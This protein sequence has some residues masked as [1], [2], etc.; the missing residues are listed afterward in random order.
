MKRIAVL[1]IAAILVL[2]CLPLAAQ[3]PTGGVQIPR[4]GTPTGAAAPGM[5]APRDKQGAAQSGTASLRGRVV[6]AQTGMPLRRAQVTIIAPESQMRRVATTDGEGRYEFR[7]L[8]A[9]RFQVSAIKAGYVTLQY[10]QRRPFEAGTPV[11][12]ADGEMV[13]RI[14][15]SLPTGSVIVVRVTDDFGEPVAGA[16]VQVQR[17][18]YGPDGQRRLT[19]AGGPGFFPSATDDRGEF[20]AYG[21]MPGDYV[22]SA[23]VRSLGVP[24]VPNANDS[25]EG[26]SPTFYP[27]TVSA[28]EAQAVAVGVAEERSVQFAMVAARMAR[29]AGTVVDSEGRPASGAQLIVI[30][31]QGGGISSSAVGSV[32]TDGSFAI[33]GIAP[34]EHS[35]EV[36]PTPRPGGAGGEFASVP[37]TVAGSDINGLRIVTGK[38]ATVSGRVVFEGTASRTGPAPLRVLPMPVDPS[39]M[40]ILF[41]GGADPLANG[42]LDDNGN[43]QLAA[44]SGRIFLNVTTPPAWVIKSVTMDGEDITDQPLELTGKSSL[45]GI[46]IRLTDK[47]TQISGRVSDGRGQLV[48]DYVVVIQPVE[49]KEP[50][51][52]SRLTRAARPDTNGRFETRGMRPGRYIATAIEAIEQGRQFSPEFREQLRRGARE[53]SVREG[54]TVALDLT[55]TPGL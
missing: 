27:G 6:S 2:P 11:T 29:I 49:E 30:S 38:G 54:E 10:G 53:F 39:S 35:V 7:E 18:Q 41:A 25:N 45:S 36:R 8:A 32:S 16:Q 47:L 12:V 52:A 40:P 37:V 55:L 13:E 23:T 51:I 5:P 42:V 20:R 44:S 48:R 33:S 28:N 31:R 22:L 21:L 4:P 34:G 1:L 15:F 43:F 46:V 26:F 19:T 50:L 17:F 3:A 14:D 24:T 9:G